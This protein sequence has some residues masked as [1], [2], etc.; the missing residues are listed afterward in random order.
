MK[1]QQSRKRARQ[2]DV[3]ILPLDIHD[4]GIILPLDLPSA[5]RQRGNAKQHEAAWA[6]EE[7]VNVESRTSFAVD[8]S[9]DT[10]H[11][12]EEDVEWDMGEGLSWEEIPRDEEVED[13]DD[14]ADIAPGGILLLSKIEA[15]LI[16]VHPEEPLFP[17]SPHSGRDLARYV[18][19][20]KQ[21]C[22]KNMTHFLFVHIYAL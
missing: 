5:S 4:G 10:F 19:A 15:K 21:T 12:E 6:G 9:A 2:S 7:D 14:G 3:V 8:V 22:G 18:M 20:L 1:R 13:E 16:G 17:G 11:E